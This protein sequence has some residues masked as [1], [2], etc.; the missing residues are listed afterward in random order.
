MKTVKIEKIFLALAFLLFVVFVIRDVKRDARTKK[1]EVIYK[2]R[3]EYS[4]GQSK[5]HNYTNAF[6]MDK[7]TGGLIFQDRQGKEHALTNYHL[8]IVDKTFWEKV[9]IKKEE[10]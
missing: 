10:K 7:I 9:K 4:V 2:Y 8:V 5:Y 3:V 1:E 6:S